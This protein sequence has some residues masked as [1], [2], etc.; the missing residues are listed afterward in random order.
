[1]NMSYLSELL[2]KYDILHDNQFGFRK[3]MSTEMA[4][5]TLVDKFHD[6]VENNE[7]MLSIFIDFSRAFDTIH[8]DILWEEKKITGSE[9]KPMNGSLII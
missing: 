1:M 9:A 6:A 7:S 2:D 4:I 8:H 3:H 5:H